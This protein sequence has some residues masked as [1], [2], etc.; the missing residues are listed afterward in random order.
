MFMSKDER[1]LIFHLYDGFVTM[2]T[3]VMKKTGTKPEDI[4]ILRGN[5]KVTACEF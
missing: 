3:S 5:F 2:K 1:F 4:S